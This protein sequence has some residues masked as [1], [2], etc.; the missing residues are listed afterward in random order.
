M[1][2]VAV[3]G[4]FNLFTDPFLEGTLSANTFSAGGGFKSV[5]TAAVLTLCSCI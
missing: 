2:D 3:I 4:D 5:I 1:Y